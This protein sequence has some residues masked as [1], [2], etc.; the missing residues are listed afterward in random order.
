MASESV[1]P[2]GMTGAELE[3]AATFGPAFDDETMAKLE[4]VAQG[5]GVS[6]RLALIA[7]A[8]GA[9]SLGKM[10]VEQPDAFREMRER[11]EDFR[12][13][14]Q[15]LHELAE[16]AALRMVIAECFEESEEAPAIV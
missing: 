1:P 11:I 2:D 10:H 16:A 5:V 6:R 13:H 14:A 12:A 7:M 3:A 9:D 15:G 8:R 4:T